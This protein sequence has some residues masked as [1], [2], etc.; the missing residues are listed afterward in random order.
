M[1]KDHRGRGRKRVLACAALLALAAATAAQAQEPASVIIVF[2]GSG[3][4]AGNIEGVKASK[5]VA[6]RDAL[7]RALDKVGPQT[8]VGLVAFGHRRGDCGDVELMRP[9][10]PL[11]VQRFADT[12]E[13]MNPRGRGP[14]TAALREAAKSIPPGPGKRSLILI[15]D[16]ADNCQ[17]NVCAMAEELRRF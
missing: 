16:D 15:H 13:R 4:M 1:W 17:Q 5:V 7:R 10:E 2:D 12:L 6:A 3:S 9:L 11:D 14:L 8:R